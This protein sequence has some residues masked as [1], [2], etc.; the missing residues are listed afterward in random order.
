M[1]IVKI[2]KISQAKTSPRAASR[3]FLHDSLLYVHTAHQESCFFLSRVADKKNGRR[4]GAGAGAGAGARD[5][6]ALP[7]GPVQP[8]RAGTSVNP[9]GYPPLSDMRHM[10]FLLD[11]PPD[12]HQKYQ[13]NHEKYSEYTSDIS[14]LY[15]SYISLIYL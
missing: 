8:S 3:N 12:I 10:Y 1:K 14:P 7:R 4:G 15:L 6:A 9:F 5:I 2:T 13:K 11:I